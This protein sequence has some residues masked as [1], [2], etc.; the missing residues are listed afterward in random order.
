M[1]VDTKI[2]EE[3]EPAL[4]DWTINLSNGE[5]T[6]TDEN[7]YYKFVNIQPGSYTLTEI[8]PTNDF[9]HEIWTQTL[10]PEEVIVEV[11]GENIE[12][13]VPWRRECSVIPGG[14]ADYDV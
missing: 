9:G 13:C 8:I 2:W 14:F 3:G 4:A 1:K 11:S 12:R 10:A 6:I 5:S 7:G